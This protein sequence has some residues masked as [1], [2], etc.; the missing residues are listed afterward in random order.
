MMAAYGEISLT[1]VGHR[2]RIADLT[3]ISLEAFCTEELRKNLK[4]VAM[5]ANGYELFSCPADGEGPAGELNWP[6]GLPYTCTGR[7]WVKLLASQPRNVLLAPPTP[8][9]RFAPLEMT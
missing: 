2:V 7:S 4:S 3:L 6:T 5:D 8:S 1:T 9:P